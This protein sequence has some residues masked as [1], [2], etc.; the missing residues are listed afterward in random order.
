MTV[1]DK[2]RPDSGRF[3]EEEPDTS[4]RK[5]LEQRDVSSARQES[6][7]T[8]KQRELSDALQEADQSAQQAG[9]SAA[10]KLSEGFLQGVGKR[11]GEFV[12]DTLTGNVGS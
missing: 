4:L 2:N 10:R 6:E 11:V 12:W 7:Q 5:P 3:S 1:D 9:R 8:E